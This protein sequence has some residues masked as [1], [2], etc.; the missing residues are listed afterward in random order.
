MDNLKDIVEFRSTDFVP[1]LP[2]D[3]QVNPGRYGAELA[4]WLSS[5]L[6]KCGIVTSYPESEDWGWYIEYSMGEGSE[7]AVHCGNVEGSNSHWLL[8]LRRFP[9]KLF[10][11]DK[12][13]YA[14]ALALIEGLKNVVYSLESASELSWVWD[15]AHA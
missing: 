5:A 15:D 9:R 2:D 1:F 6:A 7:F 3:A 13:A 10:G 12:P 14:E 11:R 4:F 8:S